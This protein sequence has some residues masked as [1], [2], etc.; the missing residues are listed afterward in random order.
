MGSNPQFDEVAA[1]YD[2]TIPSHVMDHYL[3]KRVGLVLKLLANSP[4]GKRSKVLDVGCGTGILVAEIGKHG[5]DVTGLDASAGM[6]AILDERGR[7]KSVL[8][9]SDHLPFE[10][11][12]FDLTIT[13]AVLH[14]VADPARVAGTIAEMVRVTASGGWI[15]IWDHNPNNP[16]WPIIMKRVPQDTGE[17]RL[18]PESEILAALKKAPVTVMESIQNGFIPDL[19]PRWSMPVFL[20]LERLVESHPLRRWLGAH[21]IVIAKK[22]T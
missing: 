4:N 3:E 12:T 17:E 14:H 10:A 15:V 20:W 21:N 13:A 9:Q 2:E 16:Y 11:G 19:A 6:L 1:V 5:F 22:L 7:G 18:I 8:G